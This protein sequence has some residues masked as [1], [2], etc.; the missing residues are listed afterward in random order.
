MSEQSRN[1]SPPNLQSDEMKAIHAEAMKRFGVVFDKERHEREAAIEDMIFANQSN[2]HYQQRF[3]SRLRSDQDN[4]DQGGS[5]FGNSGNRPKFQ[6]NR[7]APAIDQLVGDQRQNRTE[8]K[9]RPVGGGATE[10]I[11]KIYNG[12]IRNIEAIS[13]AE[14]AY[15][16]A[17][18][19][20]TTGGYGG[21]RVM[22][23]FND[24]DSFEQDIKIKWIPSAA[25]SLWLDPSDSDYDKRNSNWGFLT[26]WMLEDVFMEEFPNASMTDFKAYLASNINQNC[27]YW[28]DDNHIQVAEYWRRIKVMRHIGLLS[29]GRV[30]DLEEEKDVLDELKESG[31]TVVKDRMAPSFEV[32]NYKINGAEVLRGKRDWAGK[33]IP[34]VLVRGKV[35]QIENN[36][37]VRGITRFAKDPSRVYDWATSASITAVAMAPKDPYWLTPA[38]AKGHKEQ[39]ENFNVEERPF[40]LYNPDPKANNGGPP[41]RGGA[42]AVQDALITQIQQAAVDIEATTGVHAASLGNAPQ[43]LSERSIQSQAEKGDRGAFVF[44]DNLKKSKQYTGDILIDLIPRIMDTER[45]ERIINEDGTSEEVTINGEQRTGINEVIRDEETGK[46]VLINDLSLGKYETVA[47]DGPAYATKREQSAQQMIDLIGVSPRLEALALDLVAR[48]L[49][50]ND[51]EELTKRIR[52]ALIADGVVEPTEEE[53]E[54]FGLDQPAPPDPTDEAIRDNIDM[55]TTKKQAE[56]EKLDAERDKLQMQTVTESIKGLET[57]IATLVSKMEAGIPINPGDAQLESNQQGAVELTQD[58]T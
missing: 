31:I 8:I 15:D 37:L 18:D 22:T 49:D 21:W 17:F 3:N 56:I 10:D 50:I 7:I 39:F 19:E 11:A 24:D 30:I 34:L 40:L 46:P 2:G 55:D 48:N 5:E 4:N 26:E 29:D 27:R 41:T 57:L 52:K 20:Q 13:Q 32:E 47:D 58:Q 23:Q 45:V 36:T 42:P 44:S 38:Q 16:G 9:I 51:A 6:I 25:S 28:F 12:I 1:S 35:S 54:E 53:I 14:N 43:L 33:F